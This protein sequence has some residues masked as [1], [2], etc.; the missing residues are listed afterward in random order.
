LHV[1]NHKKK[2]THTQKKKKKTSNFFQLIKLYRVNSTGLFYFDSSYRPVPL[3]QFYIGVKESNPMQAKNTMND[4]CYQKVHSS[5]YFHQGEVFTRFIFLGQR[6]GESR[7][8]S[9]GVCSL[10]QGHV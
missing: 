1:W 4:I 10:A 3:T 7:K 6:V 8:P 5:R 2:H 9:Y